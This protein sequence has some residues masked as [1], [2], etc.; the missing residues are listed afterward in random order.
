LGK[1][2][3]VLIE[4]AKLTVCNRCSKHGTIVLE[5]FTFDKKLKPKTRAVLHSKKTQ[6][7]KLQ[8]KDDEISR[9]LIENFGAKIKQERERRGLSHKDLARKINEKM[10]VLK[11]I[12]TGKMIPK[13]NLVKKLE[14]TLK[15]KLLVSQSEDKF[16]KSNMPKIR[17]RDLTLGDLIQLNNSGNRKEDKT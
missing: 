9:G 7:I 17:R 4:K 11:R 13:D 15:V 14:H 6:S 16:P 1:P 2:Q 3:K 5:K 10:S 8:K 12:E